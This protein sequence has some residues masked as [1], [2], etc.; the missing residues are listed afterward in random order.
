VVMGSTD[1][2]VRKEGGQIVD[3][4]VK[5]FPEMV[6]TMKTSLLQKLRRD[7]DITRR[8]VKWRGWTG[9]IE[10]RVRAIESLSTEKIRRVMYTDKVRL[11]HRF[12]T[13]NGA[14]YR[15]A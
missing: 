14:V 12:I 4:A 1:A 3:L 10:K 8:E 6:C 7:A 5:L 9:E 11:F 13:L 2:A 15:F